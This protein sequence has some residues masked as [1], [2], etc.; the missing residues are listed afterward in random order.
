M[1]AREKLRQYLE[2]RRE[3]G[4]SELV[5]DT[6]T[7]DEALRIVGAKTGAAKPMAAVGGS[8]ASVPR[9]GAPE[10]SD[11]RAALRETGAAPSQRETRAPPP[12]PDATVSAAKGSGGPA[13]PD[14]A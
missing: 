7:V 10:T 8:T 6:M 3:M 14:V 9:A 2:Q 12:L 5:L 1:D 11:W 13:L 4:E